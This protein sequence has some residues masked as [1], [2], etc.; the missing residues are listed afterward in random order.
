MMSNYLRYR[1]YEIVPGAIIWGILVA[2]TVL[3]FVKPLWVVYFIIAFGIYWVFRVLYFSFFLV[4]G[5]WRFKTATR[6]DW[7]EKLNVHPQAK[8]IVHLVVLPLYDEDYEVLESTLR[9]LVAGTFPAQR[10]IVVVA[11]EESKRKHFEPIAARVEK[12][13]AHYFKKMII[14][15]HPAGCVDEIPGKGSNI[16][17]A[18]RQAQ[19]YIDTLGVPYEHVVVS[20]FD[21]DTIVHE[22]YFAYLTHEYVTHP[23]PTHTSFQPVALFNNNMWESQSFIRIMA[24]GTTFWLLFALT[25]PDMLVTFSS[26]SMSFKALV[27]VGF[28]QKDIVSEDSR[29]FWQ[30]FVHYRGN[31]QTHPLYIPVSMDTVRDDSSWKSLKNIYRQQRRWAWGT[32]NIPYILWH[33][34]RMKKEGK[35]IAWAKRTRYLFH[36]MEGKISWGTTALILLLFG[37]LPLWVAGQDIKETVL[38]QNT[39]HILEWTMGFAMVGILISMTL[40]LTLLPRAQ[41]DIKLQHKAVMILQWILLPVSL[42]V[43]SAVPAIEAQTRLMLGRYLGFDVSQ[44][45]RK[46]KMYE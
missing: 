38:F 1:L 35:A 34:H 36:Q 20:A 2:L 19:R 39:P 32:E 10:M 9:N 18:G 44:K 4:L 15:L 5:W 27:D 43:V 11:G 22:Q 33:Y 12:K 7:S 28:W 40:S 14:T 24:F 6:V 21:V 45:K 42:L 46:Q 29:I 37:R 17:Y 30:C 13:F 8:D 31:Y 26:H 41:S 25:R 3:S 16:N 23:D